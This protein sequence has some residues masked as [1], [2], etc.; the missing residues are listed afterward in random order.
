MSTANHDAVADRDTSLEQ[1]TS[2][3]SQ[4]TQ[5]PSMEKNTPETMYFTSLETAIFSGTAQE[6]AKTGVTSS[7]PVATGVMLSDAA[8]IIVTSA[9][10]ATPDTAPDTTSTEITSGVTVSANGKYGKY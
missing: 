8:G 7:E 4:T 10:R 5:V 2:G 6:P 3:V 9:D 1:P